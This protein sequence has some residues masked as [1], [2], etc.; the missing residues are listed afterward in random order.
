MVDRLVDAG[1]DAAA[2]AKRLGADGTAVPRH[3]APGLA[4]AW[5]G[6]A[7]T[8]LFTVRHGAAVT[9]LVTVRHGAAVTAL[10]TVR[11]G[12]A[13]PV[14]AAVN[15]LAWISRTVQVRAMDALRQERWPDETGGRH[16]WCRQG[17]PVSDVLLC[18]PHRRVLRGLW[19]GACGGGG[20]DAGGRPR[21]DPV[22]GL[23]HV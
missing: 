13:N 2:I 16:G 17:P 3:S 1:A 6:R 9:E 5:I 20:R 18:P 8:E 12:A 23:G 11:Y 14:A 19:G 21:G 22:T 15:P 7:V 4:L 10:V